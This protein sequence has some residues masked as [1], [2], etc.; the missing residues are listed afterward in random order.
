MFVIFAISALYLASFSA[1]N[2]T[3][4][5]ESATCNIGVVGLVEEAVTVVKLILGV[6]VTVVV[7]SHWDDLE[8]PLG[9]FRKRSLKGLQIVDGNCKLTRLENVC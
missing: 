5:K 6:T 4:V 3:K 2:G 7:L 8:N 1:V 9:W